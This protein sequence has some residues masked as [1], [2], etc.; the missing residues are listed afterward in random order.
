MQIR[1]NVFGRLPLTHF[2]PCMVSTGEVIFYESNES[3][4]H[5]SSYESVSVFSHKVRIR[6]RCKVWIRAGVGFNVR[7]WVRDTGDFFPSG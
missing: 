3:M 7:V 5:E 6:V 4:S 1:N 2:L